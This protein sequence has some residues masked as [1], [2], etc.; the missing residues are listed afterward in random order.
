MHKIKRLASYLKL[1]FGSI[2]TAEANDLYFNANKLYMAREEHLNHAILFFLLFQQKNFNTLAN[3]RLSW[4]QLK[5]IY[6]NNASN[7]RHYAQMYTI[8]HLLG[9]G[10]TGKK[11]NIQIKIILFVGNE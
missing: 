9:W 4:D 3:E 7:D 6:E 5:T 11:P 2:T 10:K 8:L 1:T